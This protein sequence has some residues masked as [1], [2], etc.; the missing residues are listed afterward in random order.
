MKISITIGMLVACIFLIGHAGLAGAACDPDGDVQFICGPVSPEDLISVPQSPWV[1]ISSMENEGHLYL[2]DT[3]DHTAAILFPTEMSKQQHDTG[4]YGSCPGP[5]SRQFRPHG[6]SIRSGTGGIHT[7]YAIGH[8]DRESVEVFRLDASGTSPVATWIGCVVAPESVSLNS[9]TALPDGGLA[10]TNF[11][12]PLGEVWEWQPT[13]G[14]SKVPGSEMS[15]PNGLLVSEDGQW[16]YIG[17]HTD[18][19]VIRLSRG[20]T[21][22]RKNEVSVGFQVDNLRWAPDG[23]VLAAGQAASGNNT[24]IDCVRDRKCDGFS[25][26]VSRVDPLSLTADE[27]VQYPS[28]EH[29]ILGTGAIQVG[30]EIWLGAVGGGDRIARFRTR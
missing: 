8:G 12:R 2:A 29:V 13:D 3:R 18:G 11:M 23:S 20:Q 26:R 28:N 27:I 16:F 19:S 5:V 24:V 22:I 4:A 7:L 17:A 30:N 1:I 15:G 25:S 21:P 10:A 14:W 6:L 9:V